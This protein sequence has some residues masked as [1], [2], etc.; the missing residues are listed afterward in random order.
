MINMIASNQSEKL[1]Y[2]NL[3][4]L[5]KQSFRKMK[6]VIILH[7]EV[8]LFTLAVLSVGLNVRI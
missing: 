1:D 7:F 8:I 6:T 5:F 3:H 4:L 2:S